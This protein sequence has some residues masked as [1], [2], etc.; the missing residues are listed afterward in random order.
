VAPRQHGIG[1]E[2]EVAFGAA[3]ERQAGAFQAS[4]R[5]VGASHENLNLCH[6][7][8]SRL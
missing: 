7:E 8:I 3:T 5:V 2:G 6:K 4:P 1:G